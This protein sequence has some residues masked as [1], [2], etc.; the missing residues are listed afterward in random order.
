VRFHIMALFFHKFKFNYNYYYK[1]E[2]AV[3]IGHEMWNRIRKECVRRVGKENSCALRLVILLYLMPQGVTEE[4]DFFF[5]VKINVC[6]SLQPYQ[7]EGTVAKVLK[8][9][10]RLNSGSDFYKVLS[11]VAICTSRNHNIP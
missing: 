8:E 4:S 2:I 1:T 3:Q 9:I 6:V 10:N 5:S 7:A 11:A